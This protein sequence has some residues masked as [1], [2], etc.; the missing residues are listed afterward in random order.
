MASPHVAG[1]AALVWSR[2]DVTSNSQVVDILLNSADGQGV[3]PVRLDS[4]TI[5]GG[6]N[7]HDAVSYGLANL[8]PLADA[9]PDQ[10]VPDSDR[11]GS[12]T[13]N[14]DGSASSDRDG[15]IE[16][17]EWLEG[18]TSIATGATAAV[19]LAVGTHTITLEV[20]DDGGEK[21][22]DT[23]VVTVTP[24]NQVS[25]TASAAQATE[26][27]PANGSFTVT[28]TGDTSASL[29]VQYTVAGTAAAST[30]YVP[31]PG[32]VTIEAG[33]SAAVV[34]VTPIDDTAYESN[35]TV[36]LTLTANAA[37]YGLGSP[38]AGTV[39]IVSN[40]LP[41]DLVVSAMSGPSTAGADT[42]IVVNDTTKNQGTGSSPQSNTGFYL[43]TNTTWD[44]AD[45]WLGSRPL[46]PLGPGATNAL[47]TTLHIPP[48]T[49]TGSYY[50]L[51]K[52]DWDSLVTEGVETNNMRAS[53]ALKIGP[54]LVVTAVTAPSTAVAGATMRGVGHH[55]EPGRR[56]RG[57]VHD[58]LLLVH[59]HVDSTLP[60]R[61]S[62]SRTVPV[63]ARWRIVQFH[64]D[65]A[66]SGRGGLP[67]C[68]TSSPRPTLPAKCL[69]TTETNNT[70]ASAAVKVGPDLVVTAVTVPA[71]GAAGAMISV[72]DST[73]N[74]GAGRGHGRRP[75]A[76]ICPRTRP[77]V[78]TTSSSAA[79]RSVHLVAGGTVNRLDAAADPG[80]HAAWQLLR[81]RQSRL[82]QQPSLK[83]RRPTTIGS[84]GPIRIG[85][86]LVVSALTASATAMLNG[87]IS[88][89]D[90]TRNQGL[91]PVSEST[92]AFYL[93]LNSTFD[94]TDQ[95]LGSRVVG[96]LGASATSTATT[97]F[98][99]PAGIGA[100][101]YY[102]IAVAD[103]A[104]VVAESLENNNTRARLCRADRARPHGDRAHRAVVCRRRHQHQRQR[105]DEESGRRHDPGVGDELLPVVQLDARRCGSVPGFS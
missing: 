55:Q 96:A 73:K 39:T 6:L 46:G 82:E 27:G 71:T 40:D 31:L 38:S 9:G 92:T 66:G 90:S 99:V 12:E 87:P 101:S 16:A 94:A 74:Q 30:D 59:E 86:D 54:D 69:E 103:A 79:G 80:R 13:V 102:L 95:L 37:A 50:V 84:S 35:E 29:T 26:A 19:A 20:T 18:G 98:V 53:G 77:S 43:S 72:T 61:S 5:H 104:G 58:P 97:T 1:A 3:S 45:V 75:R 48:S 11:N 25:V 41:S 93:S 14:L 17:Y 88:V 85:G 83:P 70:K 57:R 8:P 60:T 32:S 21:A 78:P 105:Y 64:R 49:A 4:W 51:A 36:V 63:L 23:L 22:T 76:S 100:G 68:I 15:T 28:R 33:S 42:D 89:T 56:Q 67:A 65:A 44:A 47:S 24:A 91:A 81:D 7:L 34:V 52:A 2:S 10:T 62:A